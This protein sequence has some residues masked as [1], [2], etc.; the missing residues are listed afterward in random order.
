MNYDRLYDM[1]EHHRLM[2][3]GLGWGKSLVLQCEGRDSNSDAAFAAPDPKSRANDSEAPNGS[4][5]R[6]AATVERRTA[7]ESATSTT[8]DRTTRARFR[9]FLSDLQT[10][11]G[12]R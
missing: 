4:I 7:P 10:S 1:A 3:L 8:T 2:R 11:G 6:D 12:S 5:Q 9:R